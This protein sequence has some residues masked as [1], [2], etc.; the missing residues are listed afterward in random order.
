MLLIIT[1]N[2]K[3]LISRTYPWPVDLEHLATH[4]GVSGLLEVAKG[5]D[6]SYG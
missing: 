3:G 5:P 1:H 2:P 6:S 4:I